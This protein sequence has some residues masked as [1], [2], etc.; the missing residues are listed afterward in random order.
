MGKLLNAPI[1]NEP[2]LPPTLIPTILFELLESGTSGC[3]KK[4]PHLWRISNWLARLR[5]PLSITRRRIKKALD[6][7]AQRREEPGPHLMMQKRLSSDERRTGSR[8]MV[9]CDRPS[10]AAV[11]PSQRDSGASLR[12]AKETN[13]LDVQTR[14][15]PSQ[16]LHQMI[17]DIS[18]RQQPPYGPSPL[19]SRCI[20][21]H[22]YF[23]P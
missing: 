8:R 6:T 13:Q 3:T 21:S 11:I 1:P 15:I 14:E 20:L 10:Y 9:H 16:S 2:L 17:T 18:A 4:S 5:L 12:L 22:R 7:H 19:S 23:R